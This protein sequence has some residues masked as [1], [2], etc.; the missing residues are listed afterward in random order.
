MAQKLTESVLLLTEASIILVLFSEFL[1]KS[2]QT[3]SLQMRFLMAFIFITL[4]MSF[5]NVSMVVAVQ[6][7]LRVDYIS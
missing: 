7:K 2:R 3:Y 5:S 1:F 6:E 4:F